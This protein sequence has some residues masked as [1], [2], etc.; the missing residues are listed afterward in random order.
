MQSVCLSSM[1]SLVEETLELVTV[2][3]A[4]PLECRVA[5]GTTVRPLT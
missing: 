1:N 3:I 4:G 2:D 5:S